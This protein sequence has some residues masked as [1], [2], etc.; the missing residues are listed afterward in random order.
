MSNK[1]EICDDYN[2]LLQCCS[3]HSYCEKCIMHHVANKLNDHEN[4]TCL[5]CDSITLILSRVKELIEKDIYKPLRFPWIVF[6]KKQ[7][8]VN[9]RYC[10]W[11]NGIVIKKEINNIIVYNCDV[12]DK[13]YCPKCSA[14]HDTKKACTIDDPEI[15]A[16][17]TSAGADVDKCPQC[18]TLVEKLSG[19]NSVTCSVCGIHFSWKNRV[20][21]W[22]KESDG[23]VRAWTGKF[24][25]QNDPLINHVHQIPLPL[26]Q[27]PPPPPPKVML[28]ENFEDV[29]FLATYRSGFTVND[30]RAF[31]R[32]HRIPNLSRLNRSA[33]VQ[34]IH[35]HFYEVKPKIVVK[36]PIPKPPVLIEQEVV[37]KPIAKS[38]IHKVDPEVEVVKKPIPKIRT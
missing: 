24:V 27:Q 38:R 20:D 1:C 8:Y 19:C 4:I 12:C 32:L 3:K 25:H 36:K 13:E 34:A 6:V 33:L 10:S 31:G 35:D 7:H 14:S 30:I 23:K 26:P 37:K 5:G 17:A 15:E 16:W 9:S 2:V 28:Q 21:L 11:C 29:D 22:S 18:K